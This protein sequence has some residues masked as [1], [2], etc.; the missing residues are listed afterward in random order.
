MVLVVLKGTASGY[1]RTARHWTEADDANRQRVADLSLRAWLAELVGPPVYVTNIVK[2][3]AAQSEEEPKI[4][5]GPVYSVSALNRT[6]DPERAGGSE[7]VR[8]AAIMKSIQEAEERSAASH[9]ITGDSIQP[10]P[11]LDD[12]KQEWLKLDTTHRQQF[13]LSTKANGHPDNSD[14]EIIDVTT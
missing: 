6:E 12:I 2:S 9:G 4:I 14:T 3:R 7:Q 1:L 13:L 8:L 5:T 10:A 11:N